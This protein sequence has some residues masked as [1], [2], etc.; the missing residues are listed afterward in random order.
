MKNTYKISLFSEELENLS[1]ENKKI[2]TF[3]KND[4][5][6]GE[7]LFDVWLEGKQYKRLGLKPQI[8]SVAGTLGCLDSYSSSQ[9]LKD[10]LKEMANR[11]ILF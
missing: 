2:F 4:N 10:G 6:Y 8:Y 7:G 3:V 5:F 1:F 9:S 11:I